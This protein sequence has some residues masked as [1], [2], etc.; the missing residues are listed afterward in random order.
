MAMKELHEQEGYSISWMCRKLGINR[1]A[2][3]KWLNRKIPAK[4]QEDL[5]IAEKIKEYHERMGGILGYR[6]MTIFLNRREGT[7]YRPKRIRRIMGILG[8]HSSIRRVRKCCTVSNKKDPKA[9]NLLKRNFEASAP[10]VKWTT[11]VTEFKDPGGKRKIYLS[12][13]MDLYDRSIVAWSVSDRNDNTLVFDTFQQAIAVYP[14]AYPLFHSDRGFQYTSPAFRK[15]LTDHYMKQSMS[16]VACCID[17]GPQEAFWGIIKTEMPKLFEYH[18]R[19]SLIE[20]IG[21]YINFYNNERYQERY[22]SK[23]PM[24]V[25][26]EALQVEKPILYPIPVNLR[27]VKYKQYLAELSE[28]K[29]PTGSA[30]IGQALL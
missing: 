16:R 4:E 5:E 19:D 11:D 28:S 13:F 12:A 20:A 23:T 14:D 9:D 17:N 30:P 3:Y 27:I 7:D 8:I 15:L 22:D 21:K 25:R 29:N 24:E 10:N 6:R 18:D 2:Y 1:A 26:T